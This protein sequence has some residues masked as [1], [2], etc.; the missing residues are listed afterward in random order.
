LPLKYLAALFSAGNLDVMKTVMKK[1]VAVR[2]FKRAQEL[3]DIEGDQV[4]RILAEA[5]LS[6]EDAEAIYQLTA[7]CTVNERYVFPPIQREEAIAAG[8]APTCCSPEMCKGS[9]GLGYVQPP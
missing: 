6:P 9:C 7:L 5:Q 8:G 3:D 4:R 2:W 1:L